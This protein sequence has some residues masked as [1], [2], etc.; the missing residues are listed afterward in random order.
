MSKCKI[1]VFSGPNSTIAN[2]PPLV[3]S[4]KA[5][6][7]GEKK[8]EGE[9]DPLVPQLLYEKVTIKI[10]KHSAH[11]LEVDASHV[12]VD[13]GKDY[14]EATLNPEDGLYLLPYMARRADGTRNGT[15]FE[16]NDLENPK[17]MFGRRQFFYP[18]ASRMFSEIDRTIYGRDKNG[19]AN[20][21]SSKA[22]YTFIRALPA[23]G[24]ASK[25]E[26]AGIDYFPYKPYGIAKSVRVG[27]L[28]RVTNIVNST[29]KSGLY[30]GAIWLEGSPSVE[31]TLYWLS[32]TIDADLPIVGN[33]AQ[34]T[35]GQLSADG[36]RN[37]SD[38]VDYI[39]S[40]VGKGLGAV[41]IQEQ[42]IFAAREFRKTDDRPGNYVAAGGHGGILGTVKE[43]KATIWFKPNYKN[44]L[45]SDV[46]LTKLPERIDLEA[47]AG[48]TTTYPIKNSDGSLRGEAIPRV[49][50]I[51]YTAF[52]QEDETEDPDQEV[53]IM[54][55]IDRA[56]HEENSEDTRKPK[57]HGLILE[58]NAPFAHGSVSQ[59]KAMSIAALSGLPVVRTSRSNPGGRVVTIEDDLF[60]EAS[61]LDSTKAR[62][63]LMACM[64]KLGRLPRA[65]DPRKPT[66]AEREAI[67]EKI[68]QFQEIF[69]TH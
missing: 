10:K 67:I 38:S 20:V 51:K 69:E 8:L 39:I 66:S 22:E 3:T 64:L 29:L 26:K 30:D 48:K 54:A 1:A 31:E 40:G 62:L 6:L 16:A 18:D 43:G 15:S 21:L 25:G 32:L 61:N 57:L 42:Q 2:S 65:S 60:I 36:D 47:D 9:C 56:L 41:G 33:A 49:H 28:A 50:I 35:H 45:T 13:D 19:Q 63:L 27:D 34:R 14:Y 37:I 7:P 11:P 23:G 4:N 44:T 5:R 55:R 59:M 58:G 68:K 53:D 52:S 46:N 17:I 12:Y 24:Y